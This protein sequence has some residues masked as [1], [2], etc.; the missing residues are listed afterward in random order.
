[1][2]PYHKT[3]GIVLKTRKYSESS[4]LLTIYTRE[5]GRI[6]AL[7]KCY[8]TCEDKLAAGEKN[9][10]FEACLYHSVCSKPQKKHNGKKHA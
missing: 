9:V 8:S 1:M 10:C 3:Q 7:A 4:K 2:Q 6:N 5:L